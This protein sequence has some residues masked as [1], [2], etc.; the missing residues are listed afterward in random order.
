MSQD[1][2]IPLVEV[3]GPTVQG[4]GTVIGQ[5]TYFLRFGLCDYKCTMCDSMHAVD[6]Q[7]VKA[8]AKWLTQDEILNAF[9]VVRKDHTT[10]WV[11]YSGGNPCI[12]DL[13]YLTA[14]LIGNG[15]KIAVETQG[16]FCPDWL[17][18]CDVVTVSPKAPGMGEDLELDKLDAF[19]GKMCIHRG[20][21]LKIV[22]FDQRD[23]EVAAMIFERYNRIPYCL[24]WDQFYLSLGNP[25]PPGVEIPFEELGLSPGATKPTDWKEFIH[26]GRPGD[27]LRTVL[28]RRY[29]SL[30]PDVLH[31]TVLSKVKFLPQW[32]VLLWGNKQG[33]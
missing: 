24:K 1:K 9:D 30:L 6:P 29:E 33:V 26:E 20:L 27:M 16:T 25:F 17:F 18:E 2:K 4:E 28:L 15:W 7:L 22:V 5:Q 11:T 3:F 21:N 14:T 23:L 13:K 31:H 10:N 19:I 8:Y 12:H 32:H